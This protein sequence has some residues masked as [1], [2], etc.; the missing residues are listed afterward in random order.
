MRIMNKN[1]LMAG[2]ITITILTGSI[3]S[4]TV[5]AAEAG[6]GKEEVV[7][8]MTN[9]DGSTKNVNVVNIFG[10]GSVT[11]YGNYGSVK[12]L[13][14]LDSIKQD[15]DKITFSS[16]ADKVYYQGT[17]ENTQLPWNITLTYELDGKEITPDNLAGKS[18]KLKIKIKIEK[19]ES[20]TS[21]FYDSYA[22]QAS[23]T[24][25]TENCKNITAENATMANVGADKQISYTVLPGKGLDA[26]ITADVTDFEMDAV[27]INA[28]KMNLNIEIDDTELMDK[29]REIMDAA[30]DLNEGADKLSDGTNTLSDGG[31]TLYTGVQSLQSG[32]STLND[33]V[34]ALNDGITQM[35]SALNTLNAQS[36]TLNDGSAQMLQALRTIQSEL[37]GVSV[38][39]EQLKQLTDSSSAIRQ[40]ISDLY[41]GA[42]NL[43]NSL[44]Y[45]SYTAAMKQG[46]LDIGGLQAGNTQA[47]ANLSAQVEQLKNAL[48][49]IQ[50]I[51]GYESNA[52]LAGQAAQ[53][54]A[55]IESLG[56][57]ITLLTGNNAA[58]A[59]TKQ[60]IDGVSQV[61]AELVTGIAT[62]QQNYEAFHQAIVRLT[63]TLSN[64]AVNMNSLKAG[65]DELVVNYEKLDS[66][67]SEY[68][69]GVAQI[70]AAYS[71]I[72]TGGTQLADG[73]KELLT[74]SK[75]LTDGTLRL[76]DGITELKS[77]VTELNDG[78]QEFYD[79]TA[80]MDTQVQDSIDEMLNSIFGGDSEVV[81]FVSDK[82][83]NVDLVQFV[84]KTSSIKKVEVIQETKTETEKLSFWQKLINLFR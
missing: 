17:L 28:V 45:E 48:A 35:E 13:N 63:D 19:N 84:I 78:T 52:E 16:N 72:V 54:Q 60:Y 58:I 4:G 26:E 82:N 10:K 31:N 80:D 7:Y 81:S 12:M 65:I 30:K 55:Q 44:S 3:A 71:Q 9:A 11:D 18:G 75:S 62:L 38:T 51:P 22:L 25:D 67:T 24:L 77:G 39:T 70:V 14:T 37:S 53:L 40:G 20:C 34:A 2:M 74:G 49:Q 43:Q 27:S 73:S 66:G 23:L 50:S 15:G 21:D 83:E 69:N 6:S 41:Q 47:L 36:S 56:N 59:G 1:R 68:T 79:K 5:Y 29:V 61:M 8:V 64:L 42:V 76:C 32:A 57:I 33:G 46:G